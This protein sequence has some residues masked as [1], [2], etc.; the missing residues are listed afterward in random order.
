MSATLHYEL[1]YQPSPEGSTGGYHEILVATTRPHVRLSF[2]R[3]YYVGMTGVPPK[4]KVR[5]STEVDDELKQ[6]RLCRHS[7]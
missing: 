5:S 6:P 7:V 1:A 2:R 3:R 4:P